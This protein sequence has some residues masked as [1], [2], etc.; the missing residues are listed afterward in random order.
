M[1]VVVAEGGSTVLGWLCAPWELVWSRRR[2]QEMALHYFSSLSSRG[3]KHLAVPSCDASPLRHLAAC[4]PAAPTYCTLLIVQADGDL[5]KR[6]S[7]EIGHY[8]KIISCFFQQ[9]EAIREV[10]A[11]GPAP[12]SQAAA[13]PS[14]VVQGPGFI[15]KW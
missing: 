7:L 15:I 4:P 11:P 8:F 13:H 6:Y 3:F 12:P 14:V 5:S 9:S 2:V 10:T 1:S